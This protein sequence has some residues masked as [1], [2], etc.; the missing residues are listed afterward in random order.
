M[1]TFILALLLIFF[2]I[3]PIGI[4][5]WNDKK[6]M[7]IG[8]MIGVVLLSIINYVAKKILNGSN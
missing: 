1:T 4:M 7:A 8:F 5:L 3:T 6:E 2:G